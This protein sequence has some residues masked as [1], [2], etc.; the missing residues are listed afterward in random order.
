[1]YIFRLEE[2]ECRAEQLEKEKFIISQHAAELKDSIKVN[3]LII[4]LNNFVIILSQVYAYKITKHHF[5][6]L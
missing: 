3:V 1:M 5:G 4:F 6:F 2:N